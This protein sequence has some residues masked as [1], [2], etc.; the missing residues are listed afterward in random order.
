MI[1]IVEHDDEPGY[2]ETFYHG[3]Y[4]T[5]EMAEAVCKDYNE[6]HKHQSWSAWVIERPEMPDQQEWE[7][8]H[9]WVQ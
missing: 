1:I 3:P 8:R 5:R 7:K 4:E 2:K 9:N 6:K